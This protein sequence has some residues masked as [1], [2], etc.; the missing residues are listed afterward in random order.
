MNGRVNNHCYACK[1]DDLPVFPV[2]WPFYEGSKLIWTCQNHLVPDVILINA[3]TGM[4]IRMYGDP[5][6]WNERAT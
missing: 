2:I 6:L 1:R 4:P 5:E 3:F